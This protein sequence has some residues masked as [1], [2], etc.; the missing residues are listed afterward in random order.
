MGNQGSNDGIRDGCADARPGM[1]FCDSAA[2]VSSRRRIHR[3]YRLSSRSITLAICERCSQPEPLNGRVD[4]IG[5]NLRFFRLGSPLL[6][7]KT[8]SICPIP[9]LAKSRDCSALA[10]RIENASLAVPICGRADCTSRAA[11]AGDKLSSGRGMQFDSLPSTT[12]MFGRCACE[13]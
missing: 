11:T 1:A 10:C 2:D 8:L 13:G 7:S 6:R 4:R 3:A 12:Y 5:N 9:R